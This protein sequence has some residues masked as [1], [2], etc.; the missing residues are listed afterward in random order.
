[1]HI[2]ATRKAQQNLAALD[3][4][5]AVHLSTGLALGLTEFPV[6]WAMVAAVVYEVAEQWV[7]RRDFGQELFETSAPES[8]PNAIVDLVAFL[9]GH[10]LGR[11]WNR[12]R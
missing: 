5:T 12:T 4:W 9:A 10:H 8:V 6:R 1:M 7:E 2:V 11:M 3:P